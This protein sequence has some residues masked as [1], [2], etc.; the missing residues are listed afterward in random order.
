MVSDKTSHKD[1][2]IHKT[3]PMRDFCVHYLKKKKSLALNYI[4]FIRNLFCFYF[5]LGICFVFIFR[6]EV[7]ALQ[8]ELDA[9]SS[10][11]MFSEQMWA[12]RF[13]RWDN[14]RVYFQNVLN[15]LLVLLRKTGFFDR[16]Y[17]RVYGKTKCWFKKKCI[18]VSYLDL[19][20]TLQLALT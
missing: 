4:V 8:F 17:T 13:D 15:P 12:E 5:S 14:R 7:N 3:K 10:S 11:Y 9:K 16:I 20:F 6:Q 18:C 19:N 2:R 1:C